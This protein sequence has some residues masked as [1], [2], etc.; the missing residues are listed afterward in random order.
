M[1]LGCNV[2]LLFLSLARKYIVRIGIMQLTQMYA[3][4][5]VILIAQLLVAA[6]Q[7]LS[8]GRVLARCQ[9]HRQPPLG[10]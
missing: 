2:F 3:G 9:Q 1:K 7:Q 5:I 4:I 10:M 8:Q 6:V